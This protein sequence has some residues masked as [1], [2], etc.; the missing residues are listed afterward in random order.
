M[1]KKLPHN[2]DAEESVIAAILSK[3][4]YVAEVAADLSPDD[5]YNVNYGNVWSIFQT[6]YTKEGNTKPEILT[7]VERSNGSITSEKFIDIQ[8]KATPI[9]RSS[10]EII[11]RHS[12][13]RSLIGEAS[14]VCNDLL[15]GFDP[16]EQASELE[17][18]AAR[19]GA[20]TGQME[21]ES[22]TI[23]ELAERAESIA[24]T[25]IPGICNR[26]FR[27]IIVA[28]EGAG[29]SVLLRTIA[30][31]TAQGIHPF[32]HKRIEPKRTLVVDLENPAQAIVDTSLELEY[33]MHNQL[34]ADYDEDRFRIW[35]RPG[36]INIRRLA[37]RAALQREIAYHRPELVCIGP[38]YKMYQRKG[39]ESYEDSADE[40]MSVL[41]DLRTRYGFALFMEHHAAK[42]KQGEGRDLTPMGSQRWMAWPEIGISLYRDKNDPTTF[43]VKRFRG[44]RLSGINWPDRISR[45]KMFLIDGIWYS[46][47]G[48]LA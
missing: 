11:I 28:E 2:L 46:D 47:G 15:D 3:P 4:D 39:G 42:G 34:G 17:K 21:Q 45:N 1:S 13:A 25:I 6:I 44:D 19:L 48:A 5:F 10:V 12:A 43:D 31:T 23:T 14:K 37:D 27:T 33:R 38:I 18:F 8:I 9:N 26:D 35:R 22:L 36:G 29:K 24:P 7:I 16:Y 40:A 41:D 30:Q 32:N 20:G